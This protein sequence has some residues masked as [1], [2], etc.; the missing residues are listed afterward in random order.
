MLRERRWN[1]SFAKDQIER[2]DPR[3]RTPIQLA[4]CLGRLEAARVLAQNDADCC[5][6]SKDGWNCK[7][8]D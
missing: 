1:S 4:V 8:Y 7:Y 2:L 3:N 5:V 6:V